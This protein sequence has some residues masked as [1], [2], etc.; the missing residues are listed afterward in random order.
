LYPVTSKNLHLKSLLFLLI[1]TNSEADYYN[2]IMMSF[3][4][5]EVKKTAWRSI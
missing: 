3:E 5:S 2:K 1:N 4:Q